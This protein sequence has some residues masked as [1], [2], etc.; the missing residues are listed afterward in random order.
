MREPRHGR[1]CSWVPSIGVRRG[2][3]RRRSRYRTIAAFEIAGRVDDET[4]VAKTV[5]Y[6]L[7]RHAHISLMVGTPVGA[8][9]DV[10]QVHLRDEPLR[11]DQSEPHSERRAGR[12]RRHCDAEPPLPP[13]S[14]GV[15]WR[16][17]AS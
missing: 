11:V 5:T 17:P 15:S 14:R 7:C 9:F 16:L 4:G 13:H 3:S 6:G 2:R 1:D 12:P 8:N 10:G